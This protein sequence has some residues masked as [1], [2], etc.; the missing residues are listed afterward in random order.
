VLRHR[1]TH[2]GRRS[3]GKHSYKLGTPIISKNDVR[4]EVK[5]FRGD[6]DWIPIEAARS[7]NPLPV[8]KY[9][10]KKGLGKHPK[11]KWTI[12]FDIDSVQDLRRAFISKYENIPKYKFWVQIPKSISHA[13]RLDRL[14]G[15]HLGH[16]AGGNHTVVTSEQV[17]SG[18]VGIETVRTVL[19]LSAMESDLKVCAADISNAFLSGKNIERTMFKAGGEFGALQGQYLIIEG[20]WCGEYGAYCLDSLSANLAHCQC[21][22]QWSISI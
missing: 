5:F 19:A 7:D 16:D 22:I 1:H 10:K 20:G 6:K 17:Y 4:L 15:N 14:N 13:L 8:I 18:V 21:Q 2:Y 11:W 12:E 9:A 3:P